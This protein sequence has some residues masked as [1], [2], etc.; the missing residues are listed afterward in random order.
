[1]CSLYLYSE[2]V[3][4][5]VM[6]ELIADILLNGCFVF[7]NVGAWVLARSTACPVCCRGSY[8]PGQQY[9]MW[10]DCSALPGGS[11]LLCVQTTRTAASC[12]SQLPSHVDPISINITVMTIDVVAFHAAQAYNV[13]EWSCG[14]GVRPKPI[15][16]I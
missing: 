8:Q 9:S 10:R 15:G 13:C 1:V 4:Q 3:V 7:E 5:L 11:H 16:D 14:L 12:H 2:S 6:P